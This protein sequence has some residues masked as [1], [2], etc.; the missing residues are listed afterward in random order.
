MS[1]PALDDEAIH[2]LAL[3]F[4]SLLDADPELAAQAQRESDEDLPAAA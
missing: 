3:L 1:T 2:A 4:L